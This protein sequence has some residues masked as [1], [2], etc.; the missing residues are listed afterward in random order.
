MAVIAI[1]TD[2]GTYPAVP[3]TVGAALI[4]LT[5]VATGT[6]SWV[7]RAGDRLL[8]RESGGTNPVTVTIVGVPDVNNR[9]TNK[10]LVVPANG[11]AFFSFDSIEGWRNSAGSIEITTSGTGTGQ[12]AVLR[13]QR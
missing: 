1:T 13:P 4:T 2:V 5:A 12:A 11:F 10:V 7:A 6:H 8:V 9:S 3:A